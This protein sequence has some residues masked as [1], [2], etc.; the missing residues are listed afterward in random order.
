MYASVVFTHSLVEPPESYT[1]N[2][3]A[4]SFQR[5]K[6]LF[7]FFKTLPED[8]HQQNQQVHQE[9]VQ[10]AGNQGQETGEGNPQEAAV[11]RQ[12]ENPGQPAE[13]G[14]RRGGWRALSRPWNRGHALG[15]DLD[16]VGFRLLAQC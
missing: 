3:L 9:R 6:L 15:L 8:V 12:E 14:G 2:F 5:V 7:A 13:G 16:I 10:R 11:C 1:W 4:G